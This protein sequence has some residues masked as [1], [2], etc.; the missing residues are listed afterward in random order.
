MTDD[1]G[2]DIFEGAFVLYGPN[3]NWVRI[4]VKW[5][6]SIC[7][8]RANPFEI[9]NWRSRIFLHLRGFLYEADIIV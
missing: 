4:N 6:T 7:P 1:F 3:A 9:D 8:L 5:F 2:K